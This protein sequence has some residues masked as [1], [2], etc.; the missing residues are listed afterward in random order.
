MFFAARLAESSLRRELPCAS[1]IEVL[2]RSCSWQPKEQR[3]AQRGLRVQ[4]WKS[5]LISSPGPAIL[6][7]MRAEVMAERIKFQTNWLVMSLV[8]VAQWQSIGRICGV[9]GWIPSWGNS[10]FSIFAKASLQIRL[11]LPFPCEIIFRGTLCGKSVLT[12]IKLELT[13]HE[14]HSLKLVRTQNDVQWSKSPV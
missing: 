7:N 9:L 10:I 13:E 6:L 8:S 14:T 5:E 2:H 11:P 4:A 1:L 3:V 12:L